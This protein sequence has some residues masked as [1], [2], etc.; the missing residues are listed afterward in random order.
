VRNHFSVISAG[1]EGKTVSDARKGYIAKAQGRKKEVKQVIELVKTQGLFETYNLVMNKLEAPAPLGYSCAGEVIDVAED[2]TDLKPGDLVACGGQGAYHADVVAVYRNL[3]VKLPAHIELKHA[4]FTTVASI[5]LQGIRQAEVQTGGNCVV[6]GL[7]LIGQLTIQLLNASGVKSIGIDINDSQVEAAKNC[8]AVHSWSRNQEGLEQLVKRATDENGADAVIIT[9]GTASLDPVELAGELCRHKGKVVI[10]GAVPTGFTRTNYYR[11]ELDLRM[12]SSYGPGRYD[13]LYEEKGIDYPVGYVRW[14][15]NRNMQTFIDLLAA[16]KLNIEK[17]ISHI[18]DLENASDAYN[19]ILD[20]KEPYTGVLIRYIHNNELVNFVKLGNV[21]AKPGYPQVGFI[22]A[23][24]FAQ[25]ILLPR[26][27]GLV[28][29]TGIATAHGNTS[30]YV[31]KKYGFDYCTSDSNKVLSDEQINT[32]FIATRHNLHGSIV[33]NSLK[34]HKN[35]FVEKPLA[36]NK[37]E[38]EDIRTTY[39]ALKDRPLLMVG[40]NRRFAP[41]IERIMKELLPE[42][43]KGITIRVNSGAVPASHWIHDPATGGGRIIGEAC[44]FVDLAI[45]IAGSPVSAVSAEEVKGPENLMDSFSAT[46]KFRN[47]SVASINY[48]SNGNKNISKELIEVF[49]DGAVARIDDFTRTEFKGRRSF[50]TKSNQDKGHK[51]ELKAFTEAITKGQSSP[52]DFEQLYHTSLVTFSI[53]E[54]IK[55]GKTIL[56]NHSF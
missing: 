2:I 30:V 34:A 46:L 10:V 22:G 54:S 13:S 41:C 6:I 15:E 39:T 5:A 56:I 7:G 25:N 3:C 31:G 1:T 27:K 24:N 20:K 19:L 4:A 36:M 51:N 28:N 50:R 23:G 8:G 18:Y 45:F 52:I 33:M 26:L 43:P 53:I 17:L 42:Q 12:S 38:L 48:F 37:S 35:V 9:A 29:F 16:G 11:K 55:T 14:T 40:Y 32:V 21:S 44:H 47:G 49:C